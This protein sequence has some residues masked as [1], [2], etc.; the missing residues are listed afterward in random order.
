M[1]NATEMSRNRRIE[2]VTEDLDK[3]IIGTAV[4]QR[5]KWKGLWRKCE[6]KNLVQF[7]CFNKFFCGE[8]EWNWGDS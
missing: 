3:N 8:E 4:E 7:N 5:L 6:R 1:S 2:G